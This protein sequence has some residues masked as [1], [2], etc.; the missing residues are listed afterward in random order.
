MSKVVRNIDIL[1]WSNLI[2]HVVDVPIL[3]SNGRLYLS[4]VYLGVN[5]T[6]DTKNIR[7]EKLS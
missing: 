6:M 4:D 7:V 1:A 2:A 3:I 5:R